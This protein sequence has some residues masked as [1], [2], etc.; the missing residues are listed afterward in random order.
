MQDLLPV[1][2]E[3]AVY[4]LQPTSLHMSRV[5]LQ[6]HTYKHQ[7]QQATKHVQFTLIQTICTTHFTNIKVDSVLQ[8]VC[9]SK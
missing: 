7:A 1:G 9:Y 6:K 8:H 4:V 3:A 5:L 2:G